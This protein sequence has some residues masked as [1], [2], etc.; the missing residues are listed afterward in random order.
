MTD[1]SRQNRTKRAN[2]A[3]AKVLSY[4]RLM[5]H[6]TDFILCSE[7]PSGFLACSCLFVCGFF[8]SSFPGSLSVW[9]AISHWGGESMFVCT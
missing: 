2:S 3:K 5:F 1:A 6:P 8:W 7:I 4:D 9:L